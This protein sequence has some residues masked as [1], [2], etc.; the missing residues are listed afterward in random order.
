MLAL[1]GEKP[2]PRN[3]T[4]ARILQADEVAKLIEHAPPSYRTLILTAAYTAMRQS[5]LLGLRWQDADFEQGVIHVR[6]QL[7]RA[8]RTQRARLV[9][10][11]TDAAAR[12]IG[13]APSWRRSWPSTASRRG[14]R[15][16]RTTCSRPRRGIRCTTATSAH[17]GST[18]QPTEQG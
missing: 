15:R 1:G 18:R 8:T 12:V 7:S 10:L 4:K 5:E 16:T 3:Q 6:N 14:S 17:V 9:P 2:A 11:K 13:M